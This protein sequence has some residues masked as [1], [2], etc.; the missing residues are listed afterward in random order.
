MYLFFVF[1][2]LIWSGSTLPQIRS[3]M[4]KPIRSRHTSVTAPMGSLAL[5]AKGVGGGIEI[6]YRESMFLK[7]LK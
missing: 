4:L 5:A 2:V 1:R 7:K 3:I 6:Y